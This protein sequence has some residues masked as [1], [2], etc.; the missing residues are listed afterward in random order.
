MKKL[1]FHQ[2]SIK[3]IVRVPRWY[4][5]CATTVASFTGQLMKI[6]DSTS[7]KR[8]LGR[9]TSS[10]RHDVGTTLQDDYYTA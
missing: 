5:T 8:A 6:L 1:V 4:A 2:P 10:E 9:Q 7:A 3:E